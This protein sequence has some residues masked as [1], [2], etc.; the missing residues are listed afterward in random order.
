MTN[1]VYKYNKISTSYSFD[2]MMRF[3]KSVLGY[4]PLWYSDFIKKNVELIPVDEFSN[5]KY[6]AYIKKLGKHNE[7]IMFGKFYGFNQVVNTYHKYNKKYNGRID[8]YPNCILIGEEMN[9]GYF[10]LQV[11]DDKTYKIGFWDHDYIVSDLIDGDDEDDAVNEQ[12]NPHNSYYIADD[13][14]QFFNSWIYKD[15]Q[16]L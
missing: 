14:E 15:H 6:G 4:V 9:N 11:F 16:D 5:N 10:F 12:M 13:F 2:D 3:L 7:E 8:L 1:M